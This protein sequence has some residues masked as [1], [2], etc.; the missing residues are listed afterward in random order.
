MDG[1]IADQQAR[2]TDLE[3]RLRLARAEVDRL[4]RKV[5]ARTAAVPVPATPTSEPTVP[6]AANHSR[7]HAAAPRLATGRK[8]KAPRIA[9]GPSRYWTGDEH[10]RFLRGIQLY[11]PRNYNQIATVVATRTP[12][13]VG[14]NP[15]ALG[16]LESH[17]A[18]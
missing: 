12:Q 18:S 16:W 3:R 15:G 13:Q 2:I 11:G 14:F 7:R 1:A 8:R 17:L 4:R 5:A 10:A 9:N 6:E